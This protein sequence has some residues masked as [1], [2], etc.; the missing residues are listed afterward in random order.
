MISGRIYD[1][2]ED[3]DVTGSTALIAQMSIRKSEQSTERR[4]S[5]L[6]KQNTCDLPSS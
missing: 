5:R 1:R 3:G 6:P 2:K 4:I